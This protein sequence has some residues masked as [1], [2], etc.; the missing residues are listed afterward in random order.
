MGRQCTT[1]TEGMFIIDRVRARLNNPQFATQ[2]GNEGTYDYGVT[3]LG[4]QI[5]WN[6][7]IAPLRVATLPKIG[8]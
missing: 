2:G 1:G 8:G 7:E 4:A 3:G 5:I 6:T